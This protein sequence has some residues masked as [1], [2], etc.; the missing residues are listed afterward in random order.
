VLGGGYRLRNVKLEDGGVQAPSSHG[1]RVFVGPDSPPGAEHVVQQLALVVTVETRELLSR[2]HGGVPRR[3]RASR[4]E[5]GSRREGE[6]AKLGLEGGIGVREGRGRGRG[7]CLDR[8]RFL[9]GRLL[10]GPGQR[11]YLA[12]RRTHESSR[13]GRGAWRRTLGHT[14]H[15]RPGQVFPRH[16]RRPCVRREWSLGGGYGLSRAMGGGGS[17]AAWRWRRARGPRGRGAPSHGLPQDARA[18]AAGASTS[19]GRTSSARQAGAW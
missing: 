9:D 4:E 10:P 6:T 12:P 5:A 2:V 3:R 17:E 7:R 15:G 8:R 11:L 14:C 19:S 18:G 13:G 1:N 16:L